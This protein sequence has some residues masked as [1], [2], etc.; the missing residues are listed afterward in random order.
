MS[1]SHVVSESIALECLT[2][3]TCI[4]LIKLSRHAWTGERHDQLA[5][6]RIHRLLAARTISIAL[7]LSSALAIGL[8]AGRVWTVVVAHFQFS[9]VESFS[10]LGA[11]FL[12]SVGTEHSSPPAT[13]LVV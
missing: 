7:L 1:R 10:G 12:E 2:L 3:D 4:R 13:P 11:L 5:W 8:L 6:T 9:G